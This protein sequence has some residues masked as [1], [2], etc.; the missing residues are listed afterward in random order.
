MATD[1]IPVVPAAHYLC[2]GVE[3]ELDGSTDI[4]GL[5][6]SGEVAHTGMHGANRLASNS[7]L[8]AVVL[9]RRAASRL[10]DNLPQ[11]GPAPD[12]APLVRRGRKPPLVLVSHL[13]RD[14]RQIMWD[15]VGI[16]RSHL[17][18][19]WARRSLAHLA[20]EVELLKRESAPG[21]ELMELENT[22]CCARLM[23]ACAC[24]RSESRG[25]HFNRDAPPA[26]PGAPA[27]DSVLRKTS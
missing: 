2:G 3:C 4:E 18:L 24:E 16:V 10:S 9:S 26:A 17:R 21:Y 15:Y 7:L 1:Q 27:R 23:V 14:A 8:E 13:R 5:L 6:V 22:L 20:E 12:F 25:L 11:P 19:E